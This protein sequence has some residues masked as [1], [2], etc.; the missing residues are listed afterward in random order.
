MRKLYIT[1][2]VV[3]TYTVPSMPIFIPQVLMEVGFRR[4]AFWCT[5][6]WPNPAI[7]RVYELFMLTLI[8]LCPLGV[9]IVAYTCIC[10][11]LWEVG[12]ARAQYKATSKLVCFKS[13][14]GYILGLRG[15]GSGIKYGLRYAFLVKNHM[16]KRSGH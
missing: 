1:L 9:M 16:L 14:F 2:H 7:E 13:F 5:P 4:V 8:L 3:S 6:D 11:A 12:P 10:V 15:W